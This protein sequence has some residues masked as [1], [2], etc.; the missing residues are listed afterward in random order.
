[1]SDDFREKLSAY[2]IPIALSLVGIVLIMG[3]LALNP[4]KKPVQEFPKESLV[5][6]EK[7]ITVDVSGAVIT[8]GVYKLKDGSRIEDAIVMAGG[9]AT[10]AN[11]QYISKGIN[12][13]QKLVDGTKIYIPFKNEEG[14][15][16]AV[17]T[18]GVAGASTASI[19]INTASQK[20][21]ES[22]PSI[23]PVTAEKIISSRPYSKIEELVS[24][25]IIGNS[26][27]SKIKD[28]ISVY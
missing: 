5:E 25:K 21:L 12:L 9:F 28:Q 13:A 16:A 2:K 10:E 1:M 11:N 27:F 23:G 17:T 22:L 7:Y 24:K 14:G 19:N 26:V 18:A 3:G 6:S 8:P 4:S 20:D 15:S